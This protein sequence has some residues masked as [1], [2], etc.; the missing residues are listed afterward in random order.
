MLIDQKHNDTKGELDIFS[1]DDKIKEISQQWMK[2]L[3]GMN[4]QRLIKQAVY[5]KP[6]SRRAIGRT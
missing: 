1:V 4:H 2:H 6:V 3:Y 5:Y